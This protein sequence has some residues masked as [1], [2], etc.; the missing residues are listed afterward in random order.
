MGHHV[1]ETSHQETVGLAVELEAIASLLDY[2]T[3][4]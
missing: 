1:F 4:R 3:Q 2:D